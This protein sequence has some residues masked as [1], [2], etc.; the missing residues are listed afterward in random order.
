M[1]PAALGEL[2]VP[3]LLDGAQGVG[4]IAVDVAALGCAFYA[5]SG[6]KWLC[7]PIGTGML[8]V[9]PGLA[10]AAAPRPAPPT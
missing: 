8:W 6:Q 7:G 2:D 4:A 5:G 10:R 1:A 9:A 3:V